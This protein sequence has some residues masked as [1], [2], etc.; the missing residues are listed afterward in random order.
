MSGLVWL[1]LPGNP[2]SSAA[3]LVRLANLRWLWLDPATAPGIEMLAW[4]AGQRAAPLWIERGTGAVSAGKA[5]TWKRLDIEG[6]CRATCP[7]RA[8]IAAASGI[9]DWRSI[10]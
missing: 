5:G 3:P 10:E 6:L 4:P 9:A 8:A 7:V 2:V 1:R